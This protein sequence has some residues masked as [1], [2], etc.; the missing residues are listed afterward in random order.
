MSNDEAF[1]VQRVQSRSGVGLHVRVP[2][3]LEVALKPPLREDVVVVLKVDAIH[4]VN[5]ENT[6]ALP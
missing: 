2:R 5:G 3:E 6:Q 4:V 1:R